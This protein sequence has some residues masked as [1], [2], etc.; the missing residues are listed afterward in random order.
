MGRVSQPSQ[1]SSSLKALTL[2]LPRPC[3][4]SCVYSHVSFF[5]RSPLDCLSS[6]L[7][8]IWI[9]SRWCG[10]GWVA[11][12]GTWA[13]L[14]VLKLG[15]EMLLNKA[16]V[17]LTRDRLEAPDLRQV[18]GADVLHPGVGQGGG[19]L[20]WRW[21]GNSCPHPHTALAFLGRRGQGCA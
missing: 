6:R 12:G 15:Q 18:V 3:P 10:T 4:Q 11:E 20:R 7:N 16:E 9:R 17:E 14:S 5:K 19:P 13:Q 21:R 2:S 8:K 1:R